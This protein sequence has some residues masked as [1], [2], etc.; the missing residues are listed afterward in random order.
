MNIVKVVPV[1]VVVPNVR[2]P[3]VTLA[4]AINV[5]LDA[6]ARDGSFV[7]VGVEYAAPAYTCQSALLLLARKP[8]AP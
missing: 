7:V 6:I 4:D 8:A 2:E 5:S 1:Y 3:V